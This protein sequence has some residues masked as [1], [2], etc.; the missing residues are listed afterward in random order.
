MIAGLYG[1]R[2]FSFVSSYL[3]KWL[4]RSAF[5]PALNE[6]SCCSVSLSTFGVVSILYCHKPTACIASTWAPSIV[7]WDLE[8]K[9]TGANILILNLPTVSW[10][11]VFCLWLSSLMSYAKIHETAPSKHF[12]LQEDKILD[13]T[14][15]V[16]YLYQEQL[17][18]EVYCTLIIY[19][20]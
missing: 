8:A 10:E 4:D 9:R 19:N 16:R 12:N 6:S 5:L 3:P 2:M 20:L 15:L 17:I 13:S 7:S 18:Q 1:R 11:T 14:H